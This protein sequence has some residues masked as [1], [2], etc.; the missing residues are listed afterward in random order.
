V[1]RSCWYA[2]LLSLVAA[3]PALALEGLVVDQRTGQ[4]IARAEVTVLGRPGVVYTDAD[5]RF[6]MKPDPP[7]PFELLVILPGERL[8]KPLLIE[9]LPEHGLLEVAVSPILEETLTV[10]GGAAPDIDATPGNATALIP[11]AEIQTRQPANLTQ[12]L[13]SVPGISSVSEGHAAVPA[14]R[15]LARGRTL[16]LLDGARVSSDRRVGPSA[17][18]LDPFVLDSIEVARGPGSVA[19]GSDAFGG[20][21]FAKT[22]RVAPDAPLGARLVAALGAGVPQGRAAVEVSKG[23]ARGSLLVQAH[24][25][26]FDDYDSP[27]GEVYNSG[28]TDKGFLAH[29][30]YELGPGVLS[31]V[32]QSDFGSDIGRPRSNSTTVR[33]SY[34]TEDSHRLTADYDVHDVAGFERA[35][36]HTFLGSYRQVTDQDRFATATRGRTLERADYSANDFQV[37]ASAERFLGASKLEVGLDTNGRYDVEAIDTVVDYTL[38]GDVGRQV[39]SLSIEDARR[40]GTGLF[41][42]LDTALSPRATLAGGLRGDY[43]T[44]RNRGGYFGDHST[45][46]AAASG[47]LALTVGPWAGLTL[48]GQLASGFRDPTVSDRYYRGPTGRGFITGNPGLRPERS[49][50]FDA[51]LRYTSARLRAAAFAYQYRIDD[52]IERHQTAPDFFFVRN[53]GRARLRGVEAEAQARWASATLEVNGAIARGEAIDDG[54]SLD[55]IAPPTL[56]VGLRHPLGRNAFASVRGTFYAEGTHPG[57]TEVRMPGYTLLDAVCGVAVTKRLA[58]DLSLRNL[59]DRSYPVSPDARAVPAPGL[60][61][62]LTATAR[63]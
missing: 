26:D 10:T 41:A 48:T 35:R 54:T 8:T 32:W 29:G 40:T 57:P 3:L 63:F 38:A 62:V 23:F 43:V 49:W 22:R 60:H 12:A 27:A 44:S 18:F 9:R 28:A 16:I 5:G 52:L 4:P 13:E 36:V 1:C 56:A 24:A 31:A 15:G 7:V 11:G 33:F 2:A 39:E 45:S 61:A 17:T 6:V 59:L 30:Q 50:Q 14:I 47:S 51:G 42:T 19:Y 20:V 25:R 21:I 34:P 37:R 58:L 53:R 46:D 55:D